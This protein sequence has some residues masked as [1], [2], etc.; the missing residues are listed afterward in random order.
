ME[1]KEIFFVL[2]FSIGGLILWGILIS[3]V[4]SLFKSIAAVRWP[5][6]SGEIHKIELLE[7]KDDGVIYL[8][9]VEYSF[10]VNGSIYMSTSFAFGYM[11]SSSKSNAEYVCNKLR[12]LE[13]APVSYNPSNPEESVLLTGI[14]KFH[15]QQI[16]VLVFLIIIF[17]P[18]TLV[19]V[20]IYNEVSNYIQT[21]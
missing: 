9:Q 11:A 19:W 4:L 13:S 8:P 20:V 1:F 21:L 18:L 5:V 2:A 14:H 7:E 3:E 10:S 15:I 16:L 17:S 6:S 12:S